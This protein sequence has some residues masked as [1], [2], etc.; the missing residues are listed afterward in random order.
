MAKLRKLLALALVMAMTFSMLPVFA[1][2]EDGVGEV[3]AVEPVAVEDV[4][5]ISAAPDEA[6][7]AD[8]I[9]TAP[10]ETV[11]PVAEL[12]VTFTDGD[13]IDPLMTDVDVVATYESALWRVIAPDGTHSIYASTANAFSAANDWSVSGGVIRLLKD[14][15]VNNTNSANT[16]PFYQIDPVTNTYYTDDDP[17]V[18][19]LFGYWIDLG[20]HTLGCKMRRP[21]FGNTG[22]GAAINI[23][24]GHILY[25]NYNGAQF[26][27]GPIVFGTSTTDPCADPTDVTTMKT[28]R[29]TV[30]NAELLNMTSYSDGN[31]IGGKDAVASV[32]WK[33][34]FRFYDSEIISAYSSGV[35][36]V[37]SNPGTALDSDALNEFGG[38]QYNIELH[39]TSVLGSLGL[40]TSANNANFCTQAIRFQ[41]YNTK[42]TDKNWS[43][44]HVMTITADATS[45]FLGTDLVF[46]RSGSPELTLN[47]PAGT[48]MTFDDYAYAMP[49]RSN[50]PAQGDTA[51]ALDSSVDYSGF[52]YAAHTHG[53]NVTPHAAVAAT[54]DAPGHSAYYECDCGQLFAD[55]ACT[56][57]TTLEEIRIEKLAASFTPN[58]GAEGEAV[59]FGAAILQ[60]KNGGKNGT[61]KLYGDVDADDVVAV[62]DK[63]GGDFT[64]HTTTA[65]SNTT[66]QV[67]IV[68]DST[69]N[70]GSLTLDLNGHTISTD[71]FLLATDTTLNGFDLNLQN[72]TLINAA[73]A[74]L[75]LFG[76][77]VQLTAKNMHFGDSTETAAN[78]YNI[79]DLRKGDSTGIF[80]NCTFYSSASSNF[81]LLTHADYNLADATLLYYVNDCTF[82]AKAANNM[83]FNQNSDNGS[84]NAAKQ[85]AANNRRCT[86]LF[87]GDNT[88]NTSRELI[89]RNA[90]F[91]VD[92]TFLSGALETSGASGDFILTTD[93]TD[94]NA[95]TATATGAA[96]LSLN[97]VDTYNFKTLNDAFTYTET[98]GQRS[99][100]T[101]LTLN[102]AVT[103]T[104]ALGANETYAFTL[105]LNGQTL[106]AAGLFDP[107]AATGKT[108]TI[109]MDGAGTAKLF[110]GAPALTF[111]DA[112]SFVVNE[113]SMF[114]SYSL[115]LE[116]NVSINFYTEDN[117][118]DTVYYVQDGTDYT[119][120]NADGYGAWVV[121]TLAAKQMFEEID[122]YAFQKVG[123]VTT[124]DFLK[125]VSVKGY[126]DSDPAQ[127]VADTDV[128]DALNATLKTML[129]Y[130]KYAEK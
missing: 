25:W 80:Y 125:N 71:S 33:N 91:A 124:I 111:A 85:A 116:D 106:P 82:T 7:V 57:P 101:T 66:K 35:G 42:D 43:D 18:G 53:V 39:G 130:G 108:V 41:S 58:G 45:K 121:K 5:E 107:S 10:T 93:L 64:Y 115:N 81:Y 60:W 102:D 46:A 123:T 79:W 99:I 127:Y 17:L 92:Y 31:A 128:Q 105:D 23:R 109:T 27:K 40:A 103:D 4:A 70:G 9:A 6:P 110:V 54:S 36:F 120:A 1:A 78:A 122:A 61:I 22:D 12:Q 90:D 59:D 113:G 117:A 21:L 37:R 114:S 87:D 68:L 76:D 84:S 83:V 29:V 55:A 11:A 95:L 129:I 44:D 32:L 52:Y 97:G 47:V 65:G 14:Y 15:T 126:A 77:D 30:Y 69:V 86:V 50:F 63:V 112:D 20:N 28:A 67:P 94:S 98:F 104:Y 34:D 100:A 51:P 48:K 13:E 88:Y 75:L 56:V 49:N 24:N 96:K 16:T 62:A 118:A 74:S 119:I 26:I 72:G 73:Q 19:R 89:Y 2:A 38:V 3:A 8:V